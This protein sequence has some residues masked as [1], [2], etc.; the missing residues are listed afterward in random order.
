MEGGERERWGKRE[1]GGEGKEREGK[2]LAS[3]GTN[4]CCHRRSL[5]F[6]L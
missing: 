3:L 1:G 4:G 5:N 6:P 2:S